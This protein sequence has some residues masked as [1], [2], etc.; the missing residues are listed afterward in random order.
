MVINVAFCK[1]CRRRR[2]IYFGNNRSLLTKPEKW[3][4]PFGV[5]AKDGIDHLIVY[6][7]PSFSFRM[8][9]S[10]SLV[11]TTENLDQIETLTTLK[12]IIRNSMDEDQLSFWREKDC[13]MFCIVYRRVKT[14]LQGYEQC[15]IPDGLYFE[16]K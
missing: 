2:L 7:F 8:D 12:H 16:T 14:N 11:A 13:D 10:H 6:P 5:V 1:K 3:K 4:D 15:P 9:V